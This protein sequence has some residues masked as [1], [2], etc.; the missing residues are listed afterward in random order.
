MTCYLG[1][2]NSLHQF[3]ELRCCLDRQAGSVE[4]PVCAMVYRL[5]S[6]SNAFFGILLKARESESYSHHVIR[7]SR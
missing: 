3:L 7:E 1:F 6:Y 5:G 2:G 4:G